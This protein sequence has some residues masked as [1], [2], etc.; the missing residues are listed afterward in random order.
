MQDCGF[1]EVEEKPYKIPLVEQPDSPELAV[2]HRR[3]YLARQPELSCA[4]MISKLV[5]KLAISLRSI[6]FKLG[7][8]VYSQEELERLSQELIDAYAKFKPGTHLHFI[9]VTGR[10]EV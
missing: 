4:Q 10:K 2:S 3:S 8:G 9:V 5:S 1:T 7:T 6:W